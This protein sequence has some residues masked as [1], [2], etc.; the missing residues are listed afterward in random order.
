MVW[1]KFLIEPTVERNFIALHILV[2][3]GYGLPSDQLQYVV[4]LTFS[5]S[6]PKLTHQHDSLQSAKTSSKYRF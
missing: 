1:S 4:V 2:H 3:Q 6:M 5:L